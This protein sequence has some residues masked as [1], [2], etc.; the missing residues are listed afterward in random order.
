ME[1]A[2][3]FVSYAHED[4]DIACRLYR[5]LYSLNLSPWIDSE[6]LLP[7][8]DWRLAIE[9]S[10]RDASFFIAVLSSNSVNKKGYV[11]KE[12]KIALDVLDQYPTNSIYIIP[13]RVNECELNDPKLKSLHYVDLFPDWR[14][15]LDKIR[16]SINYRKTRE[17]ETDNGRFINAITEEVLSAQLEFAIGDGDVKLVEDLL[18]H[19]AN[20]NY[21][22][23]LYGSLLGYALS[24]S[25]DDQVEYSLA[26]ALIEHGANVEAVGYHDDGL[27]SDVVYLNKVDV[28]KL[29]IENGADVNKQDNTGFT[30]LMLSAQYH[31][32]D[33]FEIL[34]GQGANVNALDKDGNG[35]LFY[36]I[37]H[38]QSHESK[39]KEIQVILKLVKLLI[40]SGAKINYKNKE[41]KTA[42]DY[43][44]ELE[45]HDVVH[46]LLGE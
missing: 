28:T 7:G 4:K 17:Y 44:K 27:L 16:K 20:P 13:A 2:T 12:L 40:T 43:A 5:D 21:P 25:E 1:K 33:T 10:I 23:D 39:E 42:L 41:G 45:L 11:Q 46:L 22:T 3:A 8:Q 26:K 14:Y 38:E 30:P 32:V 19:G 29:L 24:E 15:G 6:H 37:Y 18:Q 35:A 31:A 9:S 34:L 36:A